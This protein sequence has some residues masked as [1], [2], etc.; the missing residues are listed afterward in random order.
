VKVGS[1]NRAL[2]ERLHGNDV[3]LA[4]EVLQDPL[5]Q[6]RAR[7]SLDW[8]GAWRLDTGEF[9]LP[10][11]P[12]EVVEVLVQ[13]AARIPMRPARLIAQGCGLSRGEVERLI[14]EGKI[15]SALRLTGKL[16]GDFTFT[17][18]R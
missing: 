10:D 18:K 3:S 8:E 7:I 11:G 15:V 2:L 9:E 6:R 4:D 14:E 12:E 17:I 16:S 1:V 13:S 5:L